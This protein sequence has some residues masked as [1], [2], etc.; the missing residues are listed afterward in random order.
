MPPLALNDSE[1]TA[2]MA[3]C[4]PLQPRQRQTFLR[5]I[6]A[7]LAAMPERGD[8]VVHRAIAAVWREH[9]DPPL[10]VPVE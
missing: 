5:H 6:T 4:R 8:G 9:F 10:D 3:A 1:I 2:V 7:V